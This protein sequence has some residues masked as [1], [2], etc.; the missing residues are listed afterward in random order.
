MIGFGPTLWKR[1]FGETEYGI[2]AIP[3]GGYIS[4]AGM[5]PPKKA[6][7]AARTASTGFFNTLVQD[8]RDSSAQTV[9]PGDEDRVFYKLSTGKRI[10]IMLGGPTMNLLIAIALYAVLLCGF[11]IPQSSTTLGSVSA[12]VAS[13]DQTACTADDPAAPAAAA[14]LLPGDRLVSIDGTDVTSW[15]QA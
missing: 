4:M 13:S 6:G 2:K 7:E 12:C 11:G 8:A 9:A 3:L 5:F 1:K 14:G 10:I 15:D